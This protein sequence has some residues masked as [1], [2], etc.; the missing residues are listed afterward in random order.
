MKETAFF[1]L[2]VVVFTLL[3]SSSLLAAGAMSPRPVPNDPGL[4]AV[5]N[6]VHQITPYGDRS[7]VYAGSSAWSAIAAGDA[8]TNPAFSTLV[9]A[10]Q[11][12]SGRVMV[13][14]QEFILLKPEILDNGL[15]L[16]NSVNWL[17]E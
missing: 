5:T 3:L 13:T 8:D 4:L 12:G 9:I 17:D 2:W 15:F 7:P 14:G 6:G 1:V 11:F 10:R 16:S